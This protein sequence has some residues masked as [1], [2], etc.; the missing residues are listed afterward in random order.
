MNQFTKLYSYCSK[1][2]KKLLA[3]FCCDC[4]KEIKESNEYNTPQQAYYYALF[5]GPSDKTR[6]MA[7]KST[8][9]AYNY[10]KEVDKCASCDTR[11]AS[12]ENPSTAYLY[13]L[14][15]D[16]YPRD[17]TRAAVRAD[18][19][20]AYAYAVYIDKCKH[21]DTEKVIKGSEYEDAYNTLP[22]YKH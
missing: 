1:S 12:C 3:S 22:D 2:M 10:A 19:R 17:D 21:P 20:Y 13:A 7:C 8:Y 4:K 6:K 16:E 18:V 15:I 14:E 9:Y 11:E 5:K